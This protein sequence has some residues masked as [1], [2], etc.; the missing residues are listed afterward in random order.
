MEMKR[1][2]CTCGAV[3][4]GVA[5]V[6]GHLCPVLYEHALRNGQRQHHQPHE[7]PTDEAGGYVGSWEVSST[8][9]R[10]YSGSTLRLRGSRIQIAGINLSNGDEE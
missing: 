5:A 9:N 10:F 1:P 2:L 7:E 4:V 6:F 8:S 3:V